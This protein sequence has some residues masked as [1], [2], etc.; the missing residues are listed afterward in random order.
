MTFVEF[1][2]ANK[3]YLFGFMVGILIVWWTK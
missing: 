2:N 1:L 3:E